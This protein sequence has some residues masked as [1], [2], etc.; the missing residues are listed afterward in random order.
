MCFFVFGILVHLKQTKSSARLSQG[1]PEIGSR[2][3]KYSVGAVYRPKIGP[4][5]PAKGA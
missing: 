5:L 2:D 3:G 4:G 1:K